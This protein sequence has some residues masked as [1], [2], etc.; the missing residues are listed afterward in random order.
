MNRRGFLQGVFGG[1][2]AAGVIV[3]ASPAEIAAFTAPMAKDAPVLLDVPAAVPTSIG[4]H[5]YNE[6][7]Q[8]VAV[9]R[10]IDFHRPMIE[11]TSVFD[12]HDVFVP[13][14]PRSIEIHALGIGELRW[15]DKRKHPRL[16]G[17]PRR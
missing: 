2:T 4:E 13:G 1:V 12:D 7:G 8:L 16:M 10:S 15:D 9:V 3:A 11:A 17:V 5:L 6:S 14:L